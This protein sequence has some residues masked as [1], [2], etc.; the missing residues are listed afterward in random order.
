MRI[1]LH[2]KTLSLNAN[3][4]APKLSPGDEELLF[5]RE[6]VDV[7]G[8]RFTFERFLVGKECDPGSAQVSNTFT[9][10]EFTVMVNILLD[11]I[12][13]ELVDD[14]GGA[15]LKVLQ[16]GFRPPVAQ[17]PEVV[18]LRSFIIEAVRDFMADDDTNRPVV[19]G[20]DGVHVESRRLQDPCRK[21]DL[22]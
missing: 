19:H 10:Y 21:Y 18:I 17:A 6:A 14:A 15:L 9:Q 11:V 20:V 8:A 22:I 1:A 2:H 12:V 7:G 3:F 13:V 5:G 16:I 4:I